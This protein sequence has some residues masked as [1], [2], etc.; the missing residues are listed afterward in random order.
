MKV[1]LH[2]KNQLTMTPLSLQTEWKVMTITKSN[3]FV[4]DAVGSG[5]SAYV[6]V[7]MPEGWQR[8]EGQIYFTGTLF[9]KAGGFVIAAYRGR[10]ADKVT[11]EWEIVPGSGT[12]ELT[13]IR[14]TGTYLAFPPY[15]EGKCEMDVE[16]E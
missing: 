8:F 11:A 3:E 1:T 9:G 5:A 4:G 2:L 12:N 10:M 6:S 13:G 14:G 7:E 16:F 15:A